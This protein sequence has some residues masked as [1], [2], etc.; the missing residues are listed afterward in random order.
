M[1]RSNS[2]KKNVEM[3]QC[4]TVAP[5]RDRSAALNG[6]RIDFVC[7]GFDKFEHFSNG[8]PRPLEK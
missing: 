2:R 8:H 4:G 7:V 3:W 5:G 6:L 1:A